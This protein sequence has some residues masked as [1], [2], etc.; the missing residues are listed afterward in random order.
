MGGA[1]SASGETR[2]AYGVL[3][4]KPEGKRRLGRGVNNIKMDHRIV[5][6]RYIEWIYLA[7]DRSG[8]RLL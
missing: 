3:A 5:G 4:E 7:Q 6:W 1:C 2:D 8:G